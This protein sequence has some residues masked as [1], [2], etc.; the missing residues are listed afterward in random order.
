MMVRI[1]PSAD[2]RDRA[3]GRHDSGAIFVESLVAAAIVAMILVVTFRVVADGAAHART[4]EQR[5]VALLIAQ[6]ELAAVGSE[7]PVAAGESSGDSG[8]MTWTVDI[9]PY[10]DESGASTVGALWRVAVSVR[11]RAERRDLV[12]LRTLRLGPEG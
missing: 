1:D 8:D 11:P 4:T 3:R 9:S 10:S 6:S 2:R 12:R 5:R 7:I